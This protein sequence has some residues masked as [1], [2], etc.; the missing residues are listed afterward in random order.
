MRTETIKRNIYTFDELSDKAKE[1]ARDWWRE[2]A[3]W[4]D[5][6]E[7]ICED[8]ER[9]GIK[10]TGFDTNRGG[11]ITGEF[12][13]SFMEIAEAILKNHGET[14]DTCHTAR[15]FVKEFEA[16]KASHPQ[17]EEGDF[18]EL[19]DELAAKEIESEF[20]KDILH[21]YLMMLRKEI[22][23]YFGDEQVEEAIRC[24]EYEFTKDGK[25]A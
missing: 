16:F 7:Y 15:N 25:I 5:W 12:T 6:H 20:E 10:I 19:K 18:V 1:K 14:C 23:W 2:L 13:R 8:A 3:A 21:D 4:D 9:I 22:E 17:T 11:D 24:N